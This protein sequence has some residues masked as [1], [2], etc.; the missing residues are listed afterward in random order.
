MKYKALSI[1]QP[2]ASL[3]VG[4]L[5]NKRWW[6]GP[7]YIKDVENRDWKGLPNHMGQLLIH[8]PKTFDRDGY[9]SAQRTLKQLGHKDFRLPDHRKRY[10]RGGI[11]GRVYMTD[12]VRWSDSPWFVG[13][14]GFLFKDPEPLEFIPC[15]GSLGIFDIKLDESQLK[16]ITP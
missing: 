10:K 5:H 1:R 9:P 6:L 8:A 2:W 4:Y 14:I 7:K 13:K 11:V 15:K 3:C 12:A 16:P